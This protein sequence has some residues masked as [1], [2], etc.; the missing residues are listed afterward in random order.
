MKIEKKV[1]QGDSLSAFENAFLQ[2]MSE[3]Q[4]PE[5]AQQLSCSSIVVQ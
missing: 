1:E 2:M 3:T 5:A 4:E